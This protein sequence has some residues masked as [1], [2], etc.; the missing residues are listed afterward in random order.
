MHDMSEQ[1]AANTK[2]RR[3]QQELERVARLGTMGAMASTLAHELNQPLA[4]ASNY[5]AVLQ[6]M[7]AKTSGQDGQ[8]DM[9]GVASKAGEQVQRAGDIIRRMREFTLTGQIS[10]EYTSLQQ[11]LAR[12]ISEMRLLPDAARITLARSVSERVDM[13]FMDPLQIE[14][15]IGNVLKNAVEAL[16]NTDD[17]RI[18]VT[19]TSS[20]GFADLTIA[21]NGPGVTDE[22]M[23]DMF[24]PFKSTK[25]TG[26]GLGLA[27]CR[28]IVEAH[29]GRL[30]VE[31]RTEGGACF[32]ITLPIDN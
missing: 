8:L 4:A 28:T 6:A 31:Q 29:G 21:D 17:P 25:S 13:L 9:A 27:I 23:K 24:Q 3:Q 32:H 18:E 10:S 15:V 19:L 2:I 14:Q 5:L 26:L 16:R 12:S 30:T 7:Q 11:V 20:N 22:A 1:R